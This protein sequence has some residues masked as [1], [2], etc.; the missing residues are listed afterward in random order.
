LK[1]ERA[2]ARRL[3]SA[4]EPI[5]EF[6]EGPVHGAQ[7]IAFTVPALFHRGLKRV[8]RI[9][10]VD[11]FRPPFGTALILRAMKSKTTLVS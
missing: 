6:H 3:S 9:A 8:R 1:A 10:H 2:V 7:Q 5:E 4:L 11:K